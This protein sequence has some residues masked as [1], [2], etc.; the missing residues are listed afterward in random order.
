M[1]TQE[2]IRQLLALARSTTFEGERTNALELARMLFN[3]HRIADVRLRREVLTALGRVTEAGPE[4]MVAP[5]GVYADAAAAGPDGGT[6]H[7]RAYGSAWTS[8]QRAAWEGEGQE[9]W[10]RDWFEEF[11]R[12][13]AQESAWDAPRRSGSRRAGPGRHRRKRVRV[14][15]HWSDRSDLPIPGYTRTVKS[16][17][18][19]FTCHWC[20]DRVTQERFPGP[21]PAYCSP[22]CKQEARREQT[23]ERVRRYRRRQA[24]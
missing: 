17:T 11:L 13:Q 24:S 19:S 20:N 3:K 1:T 2:K 7:D 22:S 14:R 15:P 23:R 18:V 9:W 6:M 8:A 4:P 21:P 12:Q 5:M 10:T 16:R